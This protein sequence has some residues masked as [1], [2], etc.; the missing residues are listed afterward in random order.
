M[1][2][3]INLG[4]N[5]MFNRYRISLRVKVLLVVLGTALLTSGLFAVRINT[6]LNQRFASYLDQTIEQQNLRIVAIIQ[7]LYATYNSWP[8]VAEHFDTVAP[9]A[10]VVVRVKNLNN[11]VVLD[12]TTGRMHTWMLRRGMMG[13][14][15]MR[16]TWNRS[17]AEYV[18][19]GN[20][21]TYPLIVEGRQVGTAEIAV[22]GALGRWRQEDLEYRETMREAVLYSSLVAGMLALVLSLAFARRISQP[23]TELTRVAERLKS[24]N[25]SA[26]A[27]VK[28]ADELATL[29]A[30]IN[31]MAERLD[32]AA[33]LR[34]KFTADVAHE[35][36]TPVTT[37][38]SYIEALQDGVLEPTPE[39]FT[40]LAEEIDRLS[41]LIS[42]LQMLTVVDSEQP[43]LQPAA[44]DL[45]AETKNLL[46]RM[47]P[48]F[49]EK[50]VALSVTGATSGWVF[51][52]RKL[53]LRAVT[54]LVSNALKYTEAGG[55]VK[56][57]IQ[58]TSSELIITVS[59]TGQG[60]PEA[61]LPYIFDRFYRAD[62][63]RARSTGG[64][65]IGLALVKEIVEAHQ[66]SI[67][68]ESQVNQGSTFRLV[69]PRYVS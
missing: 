47:T 29:A 16:Q 10:N 15:M 34:K 69:L 46:A 12:T 39:R 54:N 30:S 26:R 60:I 17:F 59:D 41:E 63:S 57:D 49:T 28:G 33:R 18:A 25:L 43:V 1:G 21:F 42:D 55:T 20:L 45:A 14:G 35:L 27:R 58:A 50:G 56:V 68:V 61:D 51:G 65:G 66:G 23:I 32:Q 19:E 37:L 64:S 7:E 52:D 5:R 53:L 48:M 4:L 2:L 3:G 9:L 36:R 38:K 13:R 11:Q 8:V 62:P 40:E 44:V 6:L 31:A 22:L 24:G 67:G